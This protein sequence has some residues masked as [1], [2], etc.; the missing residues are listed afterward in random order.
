MGRTPI[1][2]I[3]QAARDQVGW[4][5]YVRT[6]ADVYA[7]L[8]PEDRAK[9]VLLTSNYGEAGALHRYGPEYGL[10]AVYSGQN[11]LYNDGPPPATATVVVAWTQTIH[12]LGELF[13][14]CEAKAIMDN[15]VGVDNE[16]QGSVVAICRDPVGG[17]AAVWPRLQH[18]D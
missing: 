15:G 12:R 2:D 1:P 6:V 4:P 9:A 13:A 3:N 11:E 16:E 7:R 5:V 8:P 17:W 10:P 14:S 18:Y